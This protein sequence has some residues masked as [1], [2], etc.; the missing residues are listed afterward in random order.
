VTDSF[1]LFFDLKT[2]AG[3]EYIRLTGFGNAA[4]LLAEKGL[5]GF[6]FVSQT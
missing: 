3:S 4:G 5:P 2:F 6:G 1:N